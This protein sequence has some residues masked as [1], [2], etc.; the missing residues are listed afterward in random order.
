M[1]R[2]FSW[3]PQAVSKEIINRFSNKVIHDSMKIDPVIYGFSPNEV[4]I[5]FH[6]FHHSIFTFGIR[7]FYL[8]LPNTSHRDS[9]DFF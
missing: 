7:G 9:L 5:Y 2:H 6:I 8:G 4:R 3:L 1:R